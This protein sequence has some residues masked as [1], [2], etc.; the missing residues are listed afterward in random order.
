METARVRGGA[1]VV[2]ARKIAERYVKENVDT[3]KVAIDDVDY[4]LKICAEIKNYAKRSD[5]YFKIRDDTSHYTILIANWNDK[6]S[7][8]AITMHFHMQDAPP[9]FQNILDSAS[10]PVSKEVEFMVKKRGAS[11]AMEAQRQRVLDNPYAKGTFGGAKGSTSVVG[12]QS[13][14]PPRIHRV[15]VAH[16]TPR[17]SARIK[18]PSRKPAHRF[19]PRRSPR[20]RMASAR[21]YN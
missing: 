14:P 16:M 13:A 10:N 1:L 4:M 6:I 17:P 8:T 7:H 19:Q 9:L 15:P 18:A 2:D 12:G 21:R 11:S 5:L 3:S 20:N